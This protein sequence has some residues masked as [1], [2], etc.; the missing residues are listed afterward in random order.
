MRL[1]TQLE[2]SASL[3]LTPGKCCKIGSVSQK[4]QEPDF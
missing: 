4:I 3:S 2:Y 1:P